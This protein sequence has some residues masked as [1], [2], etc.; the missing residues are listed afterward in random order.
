MN[1]KDEKSVDFGLY[2][3][4]I[5]IINHAT[6]IDLFGLSIFRNLCDTHFFFLSS[7][8]VPVGHIPIGLCLTILQISDRFRGA[9]RGL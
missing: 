7:I 3:Y 6:N 5:A 8:D 4:S 1:R 2:M 9:S